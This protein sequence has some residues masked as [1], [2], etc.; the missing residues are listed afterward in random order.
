MGHAYLVTLKETGEHE[1]DTHT[2]FL[3]FHMQGVRA[4]LP[5]AVR[6][7]GL[8]RD[9]WTALTRICITKGG[10]SRTDLHDENG[11]KMERAGR[12]SD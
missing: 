3:R 11:A 2:L 1:D 7:M 4:S 9:W 8:E 5:S 10:D 6:V 12:M